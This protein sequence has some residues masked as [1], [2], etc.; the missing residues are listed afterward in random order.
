MAD[1]IS[2]KSGLVTISTERDIVDAIDE[3]M[4]H[5]F[6]NYVGEYLEAADYETVLAKEKA[7][8]DER[9][10]A[11]SCEEYHNQLQEV[12][13]MLEQWQNDIVNS[14]RLNKDKMFNEMIRLNKSIIGVM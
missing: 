10:Y 14:K 3:Q 5:E 4:G 2:T 7:E 13:E 9:S 12:S 11:M 1:L 8:T 6:A